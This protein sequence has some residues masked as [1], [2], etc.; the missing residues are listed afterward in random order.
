[1]LLLSAFARAELPKLS[2]LQ[3]VPA[4]S[5]A[6]TTTLDLKS[7]IGY[8]GVTGQVVQFDTLLGKFNV[9]LRADAAPTTVANF[10]SYVAE[11]RYN[12]TII[13]RSTHLTSGANQILQGGGY[14]Y[15]MPP[16][17]VERKQA[18]AL[19]YKLANERGT[20]AMA[21]SSEQDSA[22]SEW[23]F[24]VD[25]NSSVLDASNGGGYAVFGRVL[26]DG[27]SVVDA[28]ASLSVY[29][30]GSPF[31]SLPLVDMA[32][33]STTISLENLVKVKS[34]RT[35]P[36]YPSATDSEAVVSFT[37][38]S[39]NPG[40]VSATLS[41]SSLILTP[42]AGSGATTI[43]I[44]STDTNGATVETTFNVTV[45]PVAPA[46]TLQPTSHSV[47]AGMPVVLRVAA[48]GQP[49][50]LQWKKD[51]VAIAGA[52]NSTLLAD[53]AGSYTAVVANG[54]GSVTS[55]VAVITP[56]AASN[57]GRL[58]NLSI[59][60]DAGTGEKTLIV[61]FVVAGGAEDKPLLLRALGP[62][63][64]G[65]GVTNFLPDPSL[66]VL[67]SSGVVAA[68]NQDWA[69]ATEVSTIGSQVGATPLTSPISKDAALVFTTKA[70]VYT[71]Q[72][73]GAGT[74]SGV[75]L[76]EI[77]DATAAE[78]ISAST[79]RLT[80]VSARAQVGTGEHILIAGFVISGET[81]RT[82]LIRGLGP[83]LVPAG[84]N[85]ALA[86]PQLTLF[87]FSGP[88]LA[89]N[90]NWGGDATIKTVAL[91][92]G[93]STLPSD[94]SKDAAL[95]V[96]LAPGVY[97]AQVSGVGGTTGVGLIEVY[98]VTTVAQ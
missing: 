27:M 65:L 53:G 93:A 92:V 77:Y 21:R 7:Y 68:S 87:P 10:L 19:E 80:N 54:A 5:V 6:V 41:G 30:A 67:P 82:V 22:T 58:V 48:T 69:G 74:T 13:H 28:L 75:A 64:G 35:L 11:G 76:A 96:T 55:N 34:V 62:T 89:S 17:V 18:I 44:A 90:D 23:F 4:Q 12:N 88:A 63:L 78:S 71:A 70:G 60:T 9:E 37:A 8:P 79:P 86:D 85:N 43:T 25:D 1:M 50:T 39:G 84:V 32:P 98:E 57:P 66:Q 72:V 26:G 15:E 20:L 31:S 95:L 52:T 97:T 40:L 51:G 73:L 38:S 16:S 81:S 14:T 33:G 2:I 29:D 91:A 36:V 3:S 46:I 47:P 59:R 49:L 24:N 42:G 83:A 56:V 61:G 94:T 45:G